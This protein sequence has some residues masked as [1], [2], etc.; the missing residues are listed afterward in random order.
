MYTYHHLNHHE[1]VDIRVKHLEIWGYACDRF[2]LQRLRSLEYN[3]TPFILTR[4][5]ELRVW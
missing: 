4:I 1:I 5:I 3:R 2:R